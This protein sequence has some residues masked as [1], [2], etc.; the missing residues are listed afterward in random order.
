MTGTV[1]AVSS[2]RVGRI[3]G[4]VLLVAAFAVFP[5]VFTNPSITTYGIYTIFVAFAA[6]WNVFSGYSGYI[7]PGHAVFF[8]SGACFTGIAANDWHLANSDVFALLPWPGF[9]AASPCRVRAVRPARAAT[10]VRRDH[11][12]GVLHLS[13]HG[14]QLA[15]DRR[16]LRALARRSISRR[17]PTTFRSYYV[18]FAL[19]ALTTAASGSSAVPGSACNCAPR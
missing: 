14:L 17:R 19:A 12:R 6:A 5:L 1:N 3:A 2:A 9:S 16:Q 7:S 4:I 15:G 18:A 8:G 10:H 13:A 11:D